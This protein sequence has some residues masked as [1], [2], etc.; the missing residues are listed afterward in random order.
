MSFVLLFIKNKVLRN[1]ISSFFEMSSVT[2]NLFMEKW[3]CLVA[4]LI[5]GKEDFMQKDWNLRVKTSCSF[6]RS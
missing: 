3:G 5:K 4:F 1:L 2:V 6:P